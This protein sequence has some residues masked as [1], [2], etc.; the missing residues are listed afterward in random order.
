MIYCTHCGTPKESGSSFCTGC[1]HQVDAALSDQTIIRT[2]PAS[3]TDPAAHSRPQRRFIIALATL[4]LLLGGGGVAAWAT[5]TQRAEPPSSP[6]SQSKEAA[7]SAQSGPTRNGQIPPGIVSASASCV[8]P[9]SQD[10]NSTTVTY[11]PENAVDGLPNTAWRCNGDAVG[12]RLIISLPGRVTLTS[13][14]LVPGYAK[15]DPY[16]GTDRYAQNRRVSAVEYTFDDGST[17][18][19]SFDTSPYNRSVQALDLPNVATSHVTIT[20]LSSVSGEATG[21]QQ[22]S[23]KIAI[24]E[25]TFSAR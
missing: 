12:Q 11:G 1:D 10:S 3:A 4:A 21:G 23:D 19:Q 7:S 8:S 20:I 5:L 9:A 14:G 18:R 13:I 2:F 22:T 17:A 24:S 16:D 25:V 6:P 15:T